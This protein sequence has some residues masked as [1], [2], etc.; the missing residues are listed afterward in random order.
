MVFLYTTPIM[1]VTYTLLFIL[2][3]NT[4]FARGVWVGAIAGLNWGLLFTLAMGIV[5]YCRHKTLERKYRCAAD[6]GPVQKRTTQLPGA[7]NEVLAL[8]VQV[9]SDLRWIQGESIEISE[10]KISAKTSIVMG[11]DSIISISVASSTPNLATIEIESRPR[12]WLPVDCTLTCT[13]D[14]E[15]I[16]E[17]IAIVSR[18]KVSDIIN[19]DNSHSRPLPNQPV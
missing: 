11:R 7:L 9:L 17:R 5:A 2:L 1:V 6:Y 13:K 14:A 18:S 15:E 8:L 4:D 10:S 19:S 3:K 12:Y 16:L